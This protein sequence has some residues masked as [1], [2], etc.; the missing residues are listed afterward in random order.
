MMID[1]HDEYDPLDEPGAIYTRPT[2]KIHLH[3]KKRENTTGTAIVTFVLIVTGLWAFAMLLHQQY[4]A[5]Y[6]NGG[7]DGMYTGY[8]AGQQAGMTTGYQSGI[9]QGRLQAIVDL[10]YWEDSHSCT[11]TSGYVALKISRDDKGQ[12]VYSCGGGK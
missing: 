2:D 6:K 9:G 10:Q 3:N 11:V 12:V 1:E 7:R 4:D 8:Q 5:G